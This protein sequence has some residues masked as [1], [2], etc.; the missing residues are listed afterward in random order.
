MSAYGLA[1]IH[2]EA[3]MQDAHDKGVDPDTVARY[4]L[5]LVIAQYLAT[6]PL[7]DVRA[8]LRFAAD[9]CSPAADFTFIRP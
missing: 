6:R 7:G 5:D 4:M 3:A 9:N 1:K 2:F 8:E